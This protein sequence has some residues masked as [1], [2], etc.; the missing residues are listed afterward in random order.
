MVPEVATPLA[1]CKAVLA[2]LD[3]H[4]VEKD[5]HTEHLLGMD[6]SAWQ[7]RHPAVPVLQGD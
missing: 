2:I 3:K 7:K 6:D 5:Q 4:T 1:T